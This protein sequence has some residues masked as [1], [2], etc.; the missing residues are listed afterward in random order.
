MSV[1][2][3]QA[4]LQVG[5]DGSSA[6]QGSRVVTRALSDIS[7]GAV[8]SARQVDILKQTLIGVS[9]SLAGIYSVAT[10]LQAIHSQIT[11]I[12]QYMGG[13]E[14]SGLGISSAFLTGGQYIDETTGKALQGMR[15]L[16]AAQSD[17]VDVVERLKAANFE[18]I[19]TLDQLVRA[20][21]ETLPVAQARGFNREQVEAFT[22]AMVQAA[23]A[24]DATGR[25]LYGLGE[26]TRALMTGRIMPG[27]SRIAFFLG[28]TPAD[29]AAYEGQADA[30]FKFLMDK[31]SAFKY[32]GIESQKT[33]GG[34]WSNFKDI[35][36]QVG[37]KALDGLF[38]DMKTQMQSMMN[39]VMTIDHTGVVPKMQWNPEFESQIQEVNTEVRKLFET[40]VSVTKY[41]W[42]H[43]DAIL[44][45]IE[46]YVAWK[47]AMMA[48]SAIQRVVQSDIVQGMLARNAELKARAESTG[49][50]AREA[51]TLAANTAARAENA[52]ATALS[53]A[54]EKD[55]YATK[56]DAARKA[57]DDAQSRR[58]SLAAR[59]Q[60]IE[61]LRAEKSER[62]S[63]VNVQKEELNN[64]LQNIDSST[65][66]ERQLQAIKSESKKLTRDL[67]SLERESVAVQSELGGSR[68][69]LIEL[70]KQKSIAEAESEA[71]VRRSNM[72][73]QN[74]VIAAREN[75]DAQTKASTAVR[76]YSA[77]SSAATLTSRMFSGALFLVRSAL[78]AMGI[79]AII[80]LLTIAIAKLYE[81]ATAADDSLKRAKESANDSAKSIQEQIDRIKEK[82]RLDKELEELEKNKGNAPVNQPL[83]GL[84]DKDKQDI[85]TW[86]IAKATVQ[87]KIDTSVY[88]PAQS[89]L[90]KLT[91]ADNEIKKII[92]KRAELNQLQKEDKAKYV[93]N[94]PKPEE[95]QFED[96]NLSK[97]ASYNSAYEA[98]SKAF[99]DRVTEA[100]KNTQTKQLDDLKF[101]YEQ[102]NISVTQYE[103]QRYEIVLSTLNEEIK[104]TNAMLEEKRKLVEEYAAKEA[105]DGIDAQIKGYG[106]KK[107]VQ[108]QLKK[109]DDLSAKQ[110]EAATARTQSLIKAQRDLVDA[111]LDLRVQILQAQGKFV[112]AENV[113][114]AKAWA[115]PERQQLVEKARTGDPTAILQVSQLAT[116]DAI[117]SR[118]ATSN[119]LDKV[120][121]VLLQQITAMETQL[122]LKEKY[123]AVTQEDAARQ[124]IDMYQVQLGILR[125]QQ[126]QTDNTDAGRTAFMALEQAI[127]NTSNKMV[128]QQKILQTYTGS[129]W[130]GARDGLS[131]YVFEIQSSFQAASKIVYDS[132]K[133]IESSIGDVLGDF[134]TGKL[135]TAEE[136]WNNFYDAIAR[137]LAN[138]AAQQIVGW[139]LEQLGASK[140]KLASANNNQL[141]TEAAL[142][143]T[144]VAEV[145][146]VTAL[147]SA[148]WGL[149]AAKAA[150][151]ALEGGGSD[152]SDGSNI[153]G[154]ISSVGGEGGIGSLIDAIGGGL[155]MTGAHTGGLIMHSG[156]VVPGLKSDERMIV[157]QTEER[158]M[159]RQQARMFDRM[160][161]RLATLTEVGTQAVTVGGTNIQHFNFHSL[162]T[163]TMAAWVSK[164]KKMFANAVLASGDENHMIRRGNK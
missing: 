108:E 80:T 16:R 4:N 144:F 111:Y 110:A 120:A 149:V 148:T 145:A 104:Q 43:R 117:N 139:I 52:S 143:A 130:D 33:W 25:L 11:G 10:A 86:K 14:T 121:A 67:N 35:T 142:V 65:S 79:G 48:S 1:Q 63:S 37:A 59:N 83:L 161:K 50:L 157:A 24:I 159:S 94:P 72:A 154:V 155:A 61:V 31:L 152:G 76:E 122:S 39:S 66:G 6:T 134:F 136:Y 51:S 75:A 34:L 78:L 26:E 64:H 55:L 146:T 15:A 135:K 107:E 119:E 38:N 45:I 13:L 95:S 77:A 123:F 36:Q 138:I 98:Y 40:F 8:S 150:L 112:D 113:S 109:L 115:T 96:A 103:N 147:T 3:E 12:L 128:E 164:N 60:E 160:D 23:G 118:K 53:M 28:I 62:L 85:E 5:I 156:G 29:V 89:D 21:Q 93:P 105:K 46:A 42:Q 22:L 81:F 129:S 114:Q 19:A 88:T 7:G 87:E 97:L 9:G 106:A 82:R 140:E 90:D 102:G 69:N 74:A 153:G 116:M 17:S 125:T 158:V 47:I 100:R 2:T 32:A 92:A 73:N 99:D 132:M 141:G 124:R 84:T 44:S 127:Q 18:T 68:N 30:Y 56:A 27:Q 41:L 58:E 49:I 151:M 71:A 70:T 126:L 163:S 133:T 162:D 54:A 137:T 91:E 57:L 131:R 20:Y 101:S